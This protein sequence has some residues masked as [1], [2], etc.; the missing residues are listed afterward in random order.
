MLLLPNE[1]S[2]LALDISRAAFVEKKINVD[3]DDGILKQVTI[4]KP[5]G[6]LELVSI[7]IEIIQAFVALPGELVQLKINLSSKDKN[8]YEAQKMELAAKQQLLDYQKELQEESENEG[9]GG[10]PIQ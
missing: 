9:L 6:A 2:V 4:K 8:L 10:D 3:F 7:P 5:S 1:A